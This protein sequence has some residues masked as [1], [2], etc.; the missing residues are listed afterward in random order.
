[1]PRNNKRLYLILGFLAITVVYSLYNIFLIDSEFYWSIPRKIRHFNKLLIILVVYGI[2]TYSLSKYTVNWMM[3]VWHLIHIVVIFS[4]VLI[5]FWDWYFQMV[6]IQLRNIAN[7][8]LEVL[9]SPLLYI[10]I[11]LINRKL[12]LFKNNHL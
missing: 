5:G 8:F 11:I 4:L 7:T 6:T 10:S 9:I 12:H 3:Q 1:M 2:G